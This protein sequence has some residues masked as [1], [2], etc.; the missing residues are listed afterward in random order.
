[1][2][3]AALWM[4]QGRREEA[5][6][7]LTPVYAWFSEGFDTMDLRQAKASLDQLR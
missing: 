3:R 6:G 5:L 1:M 7:F 2:D 4:D